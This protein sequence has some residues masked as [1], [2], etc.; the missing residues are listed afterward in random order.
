MTVKME[1]I[2]AQDFCLDAKEQDSD[3]IVKTA[4][5]RGGD[6]YI[7]ASGIRVWRLEERHNRAELRLPSSRSSAGDPLKLQ[8]QIARH[9]TSGRDWLNVFSKG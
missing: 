8:R 4:G 3:L 6:A 1:G 7:K 2:A 5:V 9:S